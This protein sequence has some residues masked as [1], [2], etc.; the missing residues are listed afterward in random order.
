[1][2]P[3]F[4]MRQKVLAKAAPSTHDPK[5]TSQSIFSHERLRGSGLRRRGGD[6]ERDPCG[7]AFRPVLDGKIPVSLQVEIALI[8]FGYRDDETDLRTDSNGAGLEWPQLRPRPAIARE[9]LKEITDQS[10]M[11]VLAYELRCAPV[12]VEVDA[13]LVLQ[14]GVHKAVG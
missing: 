5:R 14:I 13:V 10:N 8:A 11:D 3:M 6:R 12:E 1:T 7:P 9:L 4:Q 2:R